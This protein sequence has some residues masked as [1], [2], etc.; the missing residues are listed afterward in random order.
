MLFRSPAPFSSASTIMDDVRAAILS[1]TKNLGR[2]LTLTEAL[3]RY[4]GY[5]LEAREVIATMA[6]RG[7]VQ[8]MSHGT[9]DGSG[10]ESATAPR[11]GKGQPGSR[12][13]AFQGAPRTA[14]GGMTGQNGDIA[15]EIGKAVEGIARAVERGIEEWQKADPAA[16]DRRGDR[17]N[18]EGP[19]A[20]RRSHSEQIGRGAEQ[21]VR[22]IERAASKVDVVIDE[23][24]A[25]KAEFKRH[26]SEVG[27]GKWDMELRG[28]DHFKPGP[29]EIE[30][31]FSIYRDK[32][33][34]KS[35]KSLS[36]F[37]GNLL[38][39]GLVN[40]FLWQLNLRVAP[41]FMWSYIVMA[42]WGTGVVSNLFATM[43]NRAKAAEV[44]RMP[45][46]EPKPLDVYKK[47]HRV[48]DSMALHLASTISVPPLLFIINY[49]TSPQFWW[50]AIPSA[51]MG[52][53]FLA[54]LAAY[55]GTVRTLEKNL[56]RL[57]AVD[58]WRELFRRGKL[59]RAG[60]SSGQY[61]SVY[62][63]AA[64]IRDEL[65]RDL[66][67]GG[68]SREFGREMIPL[69][70]RYVDQVKML[71]QSVND[72]DGIVSTIPM[73][74]LSTDREAL[75]RKR[76]DAANP[77]LR[78]EYDRSIAEIARQEKACHDLEDQRELLKLR[79]G[80][81][82]NALKQMKIDLARMKAMPDAGGTQAMD[83]LRDKAHQLSGYLDDIKTGYDEATAD[84][85][86]ELEKLVADADAR[87]KIDGRH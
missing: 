78:A 46:L 51:I 2:R 76:G 80:S 75:E 68:G 47:L 43:R 74:A 87:P 9:G 56:F 1:D 13:D 58:S 44:E 57:L 45:V 24:A 61:A 20:R 11:D 83:E 81:S 60:A 50:A 18:H 14:S 6:D 5:G 85:Y 28:S 23:K 65:V 27:T 35:T 36:G 82:V 12:P 15:S 86:A 77:G 41:G 40:T 63:E 22:R 39:F 54:H 53:S 8:K 34:A 25:I 10:N 32:V 84:P 7:L 59:H 55:P 33:T 31:D 3:D 29:E 71:T 42:G 67:R 72:I 49:L 26:E 79:L 30:T 69:L 21:V 38:M 16:G 73:E 17:R 64:T 52:I 19:H 48:R 70:D 4:G 66:K 62:T 37:V